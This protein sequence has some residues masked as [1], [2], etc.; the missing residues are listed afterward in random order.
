MHA[1][2]IKY[3]FRLNLI[4]DHQ[5]GFLPDRS[6]NLALF[7]VISDITNFLNRGDLVARIYLDLSKAFDC[8]KH[9]L[10][11]HK[12]EQYGFRGP[13]LQ[14]F[15]SYLSNRTQKVRIG[16]MESEIQL[17]KCGVPQGSVLGPLIFVIFIN[18]LPLNISGSTTQFTDDTSIVI[19][20][21]CVATI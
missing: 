9:P 11:L 15:S 17:T 12:M 8:V 6:C 19:S 7:R 2:L 21:D 16:S 5:N 13:V 20:A 3:L 18:G 14:W 1:R 4:T 10:L